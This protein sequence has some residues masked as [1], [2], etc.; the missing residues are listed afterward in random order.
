MTAHLPKE[1]PVPLGPPAPLFLPRRGLFAAT[2]A[3]GA[4]A[5]LTA[6]GAGENGDSGQGAGSWSFIDQ[7]S[8]EAVDLD[9][10]PS[11]VVAFT[12][13]AAALFDY[14]VEVAAVFGPT[15]L[16]DGSPDLQ[17]GRM[18]VDGLQVL[19]NT[20]GE[21]DIE[22]YAS[23]GPDLL[24]SHYFEGFDLWYVPEE[25]LDEAQSL[26]P[27]VG[28]RVSSGDPIEDVLAHHA[29]L[30]AALGAD[31]E[32]DTVVAAKERYDAAVGAVD[33]AA[34]ANPVRVL[35][36]TAYTDALYVG[37]PDTFDLLAKCGELGV[38][39]VV[40]EQPDEAGYWEPLSWEN[41]DKYE[42]DLLLLDARSA[43]LQPADLAAYPTWESLPAAAA[44][45]L[46]AWNPEP[47]YSYVGAAV[48]LEEI[49]AAIASAE[50]V[51]G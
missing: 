50:P 18:P 27:A 8:D 30:A 7:R 13:L 15:T 10:S 36:C 40:A 11:T 24:V 48:I 39:F 12:G 9:R 42:A 49:A 1:F 16:A 38:N 31:L 43:S 20:W 47:V 5:L 26:A 22:A 46:F 3:L 4:G 17:A 34:A 33:E 14:G 44:G 19:G 41:A 21:F 23:L 25:S 6:C 29:E 28:L 51:S 37:V 32:S 45:Q 35:T 2:G